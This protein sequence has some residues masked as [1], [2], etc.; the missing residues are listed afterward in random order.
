MGLFF[1]LIEKSP[2]GQDSPWLTSNWHLEPQACLYAVKEKYI[3]TLL[4]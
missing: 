4:T 3:A 1:N 2:P